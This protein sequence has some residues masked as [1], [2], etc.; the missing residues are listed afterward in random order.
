MLVRH[1]FPNAVERAGGRSR[2]IRAPGDMRKKIEIES[3]RHEEESAAVTVDCFS[4]GMDIRKSDCQGIGGP[5][6]P[7]MLNFNALRKLHTQ[8]S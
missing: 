1:T 8:S 6:Y 2:C 7:C 5:S 3:E 4:E